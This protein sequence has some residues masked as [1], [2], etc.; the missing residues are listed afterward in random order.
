MKHLNTL[1][2]QKPATASLLVTQQKAL[3]AASLVGTFGALGTALGTW[4]GLI[5]R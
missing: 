4:L 2:Q 1:T 5:R 3:I